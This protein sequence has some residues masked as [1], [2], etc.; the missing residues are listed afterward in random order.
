MSTF[1]IVL[2]CIVYYFVSRIVVN[3]LF[4]LLNETAIKHHTDGNTILVVIWLP[5][6]CEVIMS[7]Y[8]SF[9]ILGNIFNYIDEQTFKLSESLKNRFKQH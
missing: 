8:L 3:F 5:V 4:N 2:I 7:C 1:W 6:V 9:L